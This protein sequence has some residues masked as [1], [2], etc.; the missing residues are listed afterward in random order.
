MMIIYYRFAGLVAIVGLT[1][2][3]LLLLGAHVH[4]RL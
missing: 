2:N 3:A 4:L 1:I